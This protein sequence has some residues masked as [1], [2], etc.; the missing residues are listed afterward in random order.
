M[1]DRLQR[2]LWAGAV[3]VVVGLIL[4]A[5]WATGVL[6]MIWLLGMVLFSTVFS[7]TAEW[8]S[9]QTMVVETP[10][11]EV[12]A[13]VVRE[14]NL[15]EDI[16]FGGTDSSQRGE[17]LAIEVAPGRYLFAVIESYKPSDV[18]MFGSS[19][20]RIQDARKLR[21]M[22]G[23][24]KEIPPEQYPMMVTFGDLNEPASVVEV[25][26][27]NLPASF[28]A[29]YRIKSYTLEITDEA[30]TEGRIKALLPW[31]GPYPE[32]LL[33]PFVE[34]EVS[35]FCRNVEHGNFREGYSQ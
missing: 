18:R 3:A 16:V 4:L 20:S 15:R 35:R 10:L 5:A 28:G 8:H 12:T 32:P 1:D 22:K 9:K 30:V 25:E 33:C 6:P 19:N 27:F 11:G 21:W 31:I 17:A 14:K 7:P 24:P 26:P 23:E 2:S 29:G 13:S 34:A